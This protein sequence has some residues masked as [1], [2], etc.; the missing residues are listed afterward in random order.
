MD[1]IED[2]SKWKSFQKWWKDATARCSRKCPVPKQLLLF[3]VIVV[4]VVVYSVLNRDVLRVSNELLDLQRE[5]DTMKSFESKKI[6]LGE[7]RLDMIPLAVSEEKGKDGREDS[8]LPDQ[9]SAWSGSGGKNEKWSAKKTRLRKEK[10]SKQAT[11]L[12]VVANSMLNVTIDGALSQILPVQIDDLDSKDGFV[13]SFSFTYPAF[14]LS[15][16][17]TYEKSPRNTLPAISGFYREL[18]SHKHDDCGS[19]DICVNPSKYVRLYTDWTA[20]DP[21]SAADKDYIVYFQKEYTHGRVDVIPNGVMPFKADCSCFSDH[22]KA[23]Q[24]AAGRLYKAPYSVVFLLVPNGAT[25]YHFMDSVLPKIVQ[26]ESF[27]ADP[28]LRFLIDLSPQHPIVGE[29]VARLGIPQNRIINYRDINHLGDA[30]QAKRL[31][32]TCNTPPLHPYLFQRA[33]YLLKLPHIQFPSK[34]KPCKVIYLSRRRGTLGGGRRVMNESELEKHLRMFAEANHYD[35]VPFFHGEYRDLAS[36]LE[37]WS[38]AAVVIGPHGGAFTNMMF[39]PKGTVVIEFLPNGA[40]FTGTTFKEHLSVYQEAMVMG[41]R[42][43][44][45]MS[46]FTKRDD[47]TVNIREVMEILK[48]GVKTI[49]VSCLYFTRSNKHPNAHEYTPSCPSPPHRVGRTGAPSCTPPHS[50]RAR[51]SPLYTASCS[52]GMPPRHPTSAPPKPPSL[53]ARSC[54]RPTPPS[55][56]TPL[57]TPVALSVASHQSR[58]QTGRSPSP[59]SS[60]RRSGTDAR[61][62]CCPPDPRRRAQQSS[63]VRGS[64]QHSIHRG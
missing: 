9:S 20:A 16:P 33:Q 42:Y 4:F 51:S 57:A 35:Y 27:L 43:F 23:L 48:N 59:P 38:Q 2:D 34:Y 6:S 56:G 19:E 39:A 61:W 14:V 44:A 58:P 18:A 15:P 7:E 64:S 5:A 10:S 30:I 52:P 49:A 54:S 31:V 3:A 40:V 60:P 1:E 8:S 41:H 53:P 22:A 11:E 17:F 26:L 63:R 21:V 24:P 28:S 13:M 62:G 36:L 46:S 25:F 50:Y 29:L 32:L 47:I 45:V 55:R 12:P 37:L